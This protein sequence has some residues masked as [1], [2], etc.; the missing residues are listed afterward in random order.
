M[1]ALLPLTLTTVLVAL[2]ATACPPSTPP[3]EGE[4][5]GGEGEG[6]GG[7]GEG[8]EGEGGE[9]EG[10]EGEGGE[11]EGEGAA[12]GCQVDGDCGANQTCQTIF[13][14]GA[15]GCFN[16]CATLGDPCTT[17]TG[18]ANGQCA[19]FDQAVPPVLPHVCFVNNDDRLP[20]GNAVNA[21]CLDNN[22]VCVTLADKAATPQ[23]EHQ[24]AF[25]LV[26][27]TIDTDCT[28]AG[29]ACSQDIKF[30]LGGNTTEFGVCGPTT[31]VAD[32]CGVSADRALVCTSGQTCTVPAGDNAGT[33]E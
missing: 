33:C 4:G 31:A 24:L 32:V 10:G 11:G 21:E 14:A 19:N 30:R 26:K 9:G 22:A 28:I 5:E 13:S 12:G 16:T 1:R 25:C 18:N 15:K 29:E 6:E 3:G 7:E 27:C 8:G 17:V 20:C 23:D 2:L